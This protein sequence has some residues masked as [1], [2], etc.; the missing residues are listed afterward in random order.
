MILVSLAQTW[1]LVLREAATPEAATQGAWP[2]RPTELESL[3]SFADVIAG[4]FR[5]R[6]VSVF[7]ITG[8]QWE[9]DAERAA[10]IRQGHSRDN[11]R[12]VF[13]IRPS[14]RWAGLVGRS[15]PGRPFTRWPVQ[16][17]DTAAVAS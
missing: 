8:W 9:S 12:I 7:E 4:V 15:N 14:D 17:L 13:E 16:Y 3:D 2:V 5:E 10:A 6:V 11:P 1:P